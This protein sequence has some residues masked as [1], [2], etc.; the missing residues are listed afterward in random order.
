[1][2]D[3][4]ITCFKIDLYLRRVLET[5][6]VQK[7]KGVIMDLGKLSSNNF[8]ILTKI[9]SIRSNWKKEK[10]INLAIDIILKLINKE[11]Q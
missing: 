6:K 10:L 3:N 9:K 4:K 7:I 1:M 5:M 8:I 2:K 11:E